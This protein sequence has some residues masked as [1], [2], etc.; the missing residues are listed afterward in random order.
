MIIYITFCYPLHIKVTLKILTMVD[1]LWTQHRVSYIAKTEKF[2]RTN[3]C[4]GR[5]AESD[6]FKNLH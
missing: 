4:L 2:P 5:E 1:L 3:E 6:I